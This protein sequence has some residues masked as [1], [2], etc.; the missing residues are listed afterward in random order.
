MPEN[1]PAGSPDSCSRSVAGNRPR[2][3]W[4]G[5]DYVDYVGNDLY[6]ISGKADAWKGAGQVP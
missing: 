6:E 4:P 2:D 3:F 5:G 1:A